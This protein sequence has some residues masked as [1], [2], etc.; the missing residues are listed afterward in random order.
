MRRFLVFGAL[1]LAAEPVLGMPAPLV[2][3]LRV[4]YLCVI[5]PLARVPATIGWLWPQSSLTGAALAL[6]GLGLL[7]TLEIVRAHAA[8]L[9]YRFDHS[10]LLCVPIG[11]IVLGG[12]RFDRVL[13]LVGVYFVVSLLAAATLDAPARGPT[14]W[15]G[16]SVLLL[17]SSAAALW[18]ETTQRRGRAARRLLQLQGPSGSAHRSAQSSVRSC[19]AEWR[20]LLA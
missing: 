13:L 10:V 8:A 9:G 18:M 14:G 15:L 16:E 4:L 3:L 2:D 17:M 20:H 19:P 6:A 1:I 7:V 5:L 11:L 12:F